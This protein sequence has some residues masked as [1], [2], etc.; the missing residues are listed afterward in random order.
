MGVR[1]FQYPYMGV[2]WNRGTHPLLDTIF[3]ELSTFQLW[4]PLYGCSI[5][6]QIQS[7][8]R[9]WSSLHMKP[10][11]HPEGVR[12]ISMAK[13]QVTTDQSTT[14]WIGSVTVRKVRN[15]WNGRWSQHGIMTLNCVSWNLCHRLPIF[16][17][18]AELMR[19]VYWARWNNRIPINW[20]WLVSCKA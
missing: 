5:I 15:M 9:L 19:L 13:E 3:H 18:P 10:E 4:K 14:Q 7:N 12:R 16:L 11:P 1:C 8:L 6:E 20:N 2:S 17:Q